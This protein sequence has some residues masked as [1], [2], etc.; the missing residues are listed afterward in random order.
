MTIS[1]A[2]Y[3]PTPEHHDMALNL[4]K[5][6]SLPLVRNQTLEFRYLLFFSQQGLALKQTG[7]N[8]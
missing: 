5:K 2:I 7:G 8:R 6:L 1:V 4:S 3:A